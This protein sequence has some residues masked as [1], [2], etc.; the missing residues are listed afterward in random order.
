MN[1]PKRHSRTRQSLP[2]L[3]SILASS[4]SLAG[5]MADGKS[6]PKSHSEPAIPQDALSTHQRNDSMT[7]S[8]AEPSPLLMPKSSGGSSL[9]VNELSR[10]QSFSDISSYQDQ[11]EWETP[12]ENVT[13]FDLLDNLA[14]PSTLERWQN[15][16]A[17]QTERVRKQRERLRSTTAG[18]KDR[19]VEEWRRRVPPTDEQFDKY[20]KRVKTSVDRLGK[21]WTDTKA[22]TA[23]EKVAFIAGVLNI[24]IS[25]YI[26]GAIPQYYYWWF[27]I[28]FAYFMPIRYY[29]Y[30]RRGYHYFLADMCYFVNFLL[31]ATIWVAPQ[32][33]RLFIATYCLANGNNAVAIAMWRNSLV[34]H[35]LDKV[36]RYVT[37]PSLNS[38]RVSHLLS[39]V[40]SSTLCLQSPSIVSSISPLPRCRKCDFQGFGPSNI[41][42]LT[43]PSTTRLFP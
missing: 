26:I 27:T 25:G 22:V 33:K 24:F 14:L 42:L 38:Q 20:R 16:I 10:N 13:V 6:L 31:I 40:Y 19:V 4:N 43:A 37:R 35:S 15:R 39:L 32:S 2:S 9:S 34:F 28:Q 30:Q 29:T 3:D 18:A 17:A 5:S 23:R 7:S 12:M 8:T 11:E 1:S 36:T 21:R 41:V